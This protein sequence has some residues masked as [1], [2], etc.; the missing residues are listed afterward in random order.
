MPKRN[1]GGSGLFF[2][3]TPKMNEYV[4]RISNVKKERFD[5]WILSCVRACALGETSSQ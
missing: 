2:G 5:S 3:V 1:V 4:V